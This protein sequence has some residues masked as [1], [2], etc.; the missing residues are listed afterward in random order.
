MENFRVQAEALKQQLQSGSQSQAGNLGDGLA[1][2]MARANLL[3]LTTSANT[4][5]SLTNASQPSSQTNNNSSPPITINN[6]SSNNT[7]LSMQIGDINA[8]RDSSSNY[9]NDLD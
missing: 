6:Q 4:A 9:A 8:L 5:N 1:V 2:L 7:G 3:G